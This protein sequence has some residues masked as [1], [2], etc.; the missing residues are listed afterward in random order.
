MQLLFLALVT[1]YLCGSIP[2]A[3]WLGL[4]FYKCN[5]FEHGS[6]NMGATN[7]YRVLGKVPFAITLM[8]D[9]L[10]GMAAV[11]ISAHIFANATAIFFSAAGALLGHTFSFW[12]K[13]RGGK[14][15]AT[16]LGIFLALAAKSS[17]ASLGIF[18]V[19]LLA[20][21]MVSL[22]SIFAAALLPVFIFWFQELGPV[23]NFYLTSLSAIMA[24]FVI[25]K[26]KANI[27]RIL[28]GQE[29]KLGQKSE[30]KNSETTEIPTEKPGETV[31]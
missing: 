31:R 5:I 22:S 4:I 2:S 29:L 17:L 12:V 6:K 9:I 8:L 3:Y 14:G 19:V 18:L 11:I 16:G 28:K 13:F 21:K 24:I 1:G 20:S 25:Y 23:Y 10:K 27:K 7:V 26:H 30:D 15:V